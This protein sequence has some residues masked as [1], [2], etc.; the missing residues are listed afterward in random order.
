M[1]ISL[2]SDE[3]CRI[4]VF[5]LEGKPCCTCVS[6]WYNDTGYPAPGIDQSQPIGRRWSRCD[7]TKLY[8]FEAGFRRDHRCID[9]ALTGVITGEDVTIDNIDRWGK[10]RLPMINGSLKVYVVIDFQSEPATAELE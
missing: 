10:R 2:M 8:S 1:L 9:G 4:M 6:E 5:C 7:H 3:W